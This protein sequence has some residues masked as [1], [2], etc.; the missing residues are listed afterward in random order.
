[1]D[2][3]D[4]KKKILAMLRQSLEPS[5]VIS[6]IGDCECYSMVDYDQY[7]R[8]TMS[9]EAVRIF[10]THCRD[11]PSC[12]KGI[13]QSQEKFD[14]KRERFE[15]EILFQK[16][17]DI[18]DKLEKNVI[19]VIIEK[20]RD[21]L[22]LIK[23]TGEILRTPTAPAFRVEKGEAREEQT[24][25]VI[26]EFASPP[27]SVQASF[28]THE[29]GGKIGLKISVFNRYSEEFMPDVKITLEGPDVKESAISD[30][31][32]EAEFILKGP[33][34]YRANL[35]TEEEQLARLNITITE[36]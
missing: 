36:Q 4:F 2:K 18:L 6:N 12:L 21:I 11:C 26:Q 25:R 29:P 1:V 28:E 15:N 31:N 34:E 19:N 30:E 17:M 16:T 3:K 22:K 5:T 14:R 23:T 35:R 20:S 7:I 27:V 8:G 24:V 13:V 32:G 33:G 10:E 9:V